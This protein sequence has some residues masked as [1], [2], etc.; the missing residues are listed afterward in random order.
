MKSLLV[1][2]LFITIMLSVSFDSPASLIKS[3]PGNERLCML[4]SFKTS[5]TETSF[6]DYTINQNSVEID[7]WRLQG[8]MGMGFIPVHDPRLIFNISKGAHTMKVV[9]VI[10]INQHDTEG[11]PEIECEAQK[12]G[13]FLP[14]NGSRFGIPK[15]K[16]TALYFNDTGFTNAGERFFK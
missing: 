8:L 11:G 10:S 1:G 7:N 13:I 9:L 14:R 3:T 6:K 16:Y 4:D 12:F 2:F 5:L 15:K